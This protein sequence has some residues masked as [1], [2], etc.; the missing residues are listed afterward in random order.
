MIGAALAATLVPSS[1]AA[2]PRARLRELGMRPGLLEP[3]SANAIAD[4]G[5]VTV[6]HATLLSGEP[7]LVVGRGPIRTGV[8]AVLPRGRVAAPPCR[9]GA[10]IL[11]GNG[12]MTGVM[13]IRRTGLLAAPVLLTG[14]ANIGIVYDAAVRLAREAGVGSSSPVVAECWDG[15]GDVRGRHL[16]AEHV[17][18]AVASA[19]PGRPAEGAVGGGTGMTCYGFKGG[20]GT[21]SRVTAGEGPRYTVGVLVN[22]NHGTRR[23]LTIAGVPVGVELAEY[24]G[25]SERSSSSIVMIAATDAPLAPRQLER[26]AIRLGLGLART[27][28]TA[29][30]TSG[31]LMLAFSTAPTDA[32]PLADDAMSPLYQAAVEATEEAV[33]N[34]L[35]MAVDVVGAD[36]T[37]VPALP[38]DRVVAILRRRGAIA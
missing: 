30:T 10:A 1:G 28:A 12:E 9:A 22:A 26:V 14:T 5:G 15:I 34:A 8:T 19:A 25:D 13:A 21:A 38:L 23:Q 2:S 36:G 35:A 11:N 24:G 32:S 20:V 33:L 37:L 29:N 3:G 27:G 6:G 18:Q 4:V 17:R 7:P 31:D 16:R